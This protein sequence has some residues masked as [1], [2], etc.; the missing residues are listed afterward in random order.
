LGISRSRLYQVFSGT[1]PMEELTRLRL[2][3]A[4]AML[5]DPALAQATNSEIATRSGFASVRSF[6]RAF[7]RRYSITPSS[8]R[9]DVTSER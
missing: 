7:R 3:K 6:Q 4:R 5:R 9:H 8:Y 1:S 2:E